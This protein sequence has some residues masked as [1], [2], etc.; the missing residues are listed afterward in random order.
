MLR[1]EEEQL[2]YDIESYKL[3]PLDIVNSPL[4]NIFESLRENERMP[5]NSFLVRYDFSIK[6]EDIDLYNNSRLSLKDV[7]PVESMV[8]DMETIALIYLV[9]EA[10][11][12]LCIT[13]ENFCILGQP[14]G[15][16]L[17]YTQ[18]LQTV[19]VDK[20]SYWVQDIEPYYIGTLKA[21]TKLFKFNQLDKS[22]KVIII[23][24]NDRVSAYSNSESQIELDNKVV[25]AY[26]NKIGLLKTYIG[27][28][29]GQNALPWL[30]IGPRQNPPSPPI[31]TTQC[32][33]CYQ[34][35]PNTK[36]FEVLDV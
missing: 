11:T 20:T 1:E 13:S 2:D 12:D 3:H 7:T 10:Y 29:P 4:I 22:A 15:K 16:D 36:A 21:I 26:S 6:A 24:D 18:V 19:T 8:K 30:R 35:I 25:K 5:E 28:E 32:G 23:P 17:N 33:A 14:L 31:R 27:E 9:S 34:F